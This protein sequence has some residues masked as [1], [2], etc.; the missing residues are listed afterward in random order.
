[1]RNFTD[2]LADYDLTDDMRDRLLAHARQDAALAAPNA[3]IKR[4]LWAILI[5][6]ILIL[7]GHMH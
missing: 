5:V 3:A 6:C 7:M 2:A 4:L 1:M